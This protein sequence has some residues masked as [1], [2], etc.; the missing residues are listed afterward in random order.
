MTAVLPYMKWPSRIFGKLLPLVSPMGVIDWVLDRI[1]NLWSKRRQPG[2]TDKVCHWQKLHKHFPSK[3]TALHVCGFCLGPWCRKILD[4]QVERV[5]WP[6]SGPTRPNL[7]KM[8]WGV[9]GREGFLEDAQYC[10]CVGLRRRRRCF[11]EEGGTREERLKLADSATSP[12]VVE[13]DKGMAMEGVWEKERQETATGD[14][15]QAQ[16]I[17]KHHAQQPISSGLRVLESAKATRDR[18]GRQHEF[19]QINHSIVGI[20]DTDSSEWFFQTILA[21]LVHSAVPAGCSQCWMH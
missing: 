11:G 3:A 9:E 10:T 1:E 21:C 7:V 19:C 18:L 20:G 16:P 15:N 12:R 6:L 5:Q 13:E 17:A 2:R 4:K 8:G 14:N